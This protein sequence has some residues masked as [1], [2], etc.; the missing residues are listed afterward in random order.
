MIERREEP[1]PQTLKDLLHPL[2]GYINQGIISPVLAVIGGIMF[3]L[4]EQRELWH[5]GALNVGA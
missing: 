4:C 3:L 1:L 2:D 5:L